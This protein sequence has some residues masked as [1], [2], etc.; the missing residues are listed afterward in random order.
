MIVDSSNNVLNSFKEILTLP[1]AQKLDEETVNKINSA[2]AEV[3]NQRKEYEPTKEQLKEYPWL[4]NAVNGIRKVSDIIENFKNG[5][6]GS[7]DFTITSASQDSFDVYNGNGRTHYYN[8]YAQ[9]DYT[10][11]FSI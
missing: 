6:D 11:T 1:K 5:E 3:D 4:K 2:I 10:T 9:V 7:G 8:I